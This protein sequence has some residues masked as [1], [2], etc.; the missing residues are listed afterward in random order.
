MA[1]RPSPGAVSPTSQPL[2]HLCLRAAAGS[3][4]IVG[5]RPRESGWEN[6]DWDCGCWGHQ[7]CAVAGISAGDG[8]G[9]ASCSAQYTSTAGQ[10]Q[11]SQTAGAAA[12]FGAA[13]C[14]VLHSWGHGQAALMGRNTNSNLK[15]SPNAVHGRDGW[16]GCRTPTAPIP[17][18][19]SHG[20]SYL[21][22]HVLYPGAALCSEEPKG[23]RA[24]GCDDKHSLF[25][26]HGERRSENK[27]MEGLIK[28]TGQYLLS[29]LIKALFRSGR[30]HQ[31]HDWD[32]EQDGGSLLCP[33]ADKRGREG[34]C[35]GKSNTCPLVPPW[36]I[37]A[38]PCSH[39]QPLHLPL[40]TQQCRHR[41]LSPLPVQS[42]E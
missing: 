32:V 26:T 40:C 28:S 38:V 8:D 36:S 13:C 4:V 15:P 12:A 27:Q 34:K 11:V 9:S 41:C 6:T 20:H 39:P 42:S 24:P 19:P 37:P 30:Q 18:R 33:A 5:R 3:K 2:H 16:K 31:S 7:S 25:W 17:P 1:P 10:T 35:S 14:G 23:A 21:L 22:P 29:G